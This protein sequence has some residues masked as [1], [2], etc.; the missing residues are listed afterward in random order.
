MR[1]GASFCAAFDN[2]LITAVT[3]K[4]GFSFSPTTNDLQYHITLDIPEDRSIGGGVRV[5]V[6]EL[7][8]AAAA[9]AAGS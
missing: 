7:M 5:E 1:S 2:G 9:A 8:L 6:G 4:V 3:T